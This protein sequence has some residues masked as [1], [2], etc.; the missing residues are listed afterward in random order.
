MRMVKGGAPGM[1]AAGMWTAIRDNPD[2]ARPEMP[3]EVAGYEDI[4]AAMPP[5]RGHLKRLARKPATFVDVPK[6]YRPMSETLRVQLDFHKRVIA[7]LGGSRTIVASD[8]REIKP[9]VFIAPCEEL[10]RKETRPVLTDA[11][12]RD[13][14]QARRKMLYHEHQEDWVQ[15]M[16]AGLL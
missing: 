13:H 8:V 7:E 9:K 11:K 3:S 1:T 15:N 6:V 4:F 12:L 14:I 10:D 2:L 16:E 5:S